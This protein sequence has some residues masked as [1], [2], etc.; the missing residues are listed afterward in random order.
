MGLTV[1]D[2]TDMLD[3][4]FTERLRAM[5]AGEPLAGADGR[6]HP[7]DS[8]TRIDPDEGAALVRLAVRVG[9]DRTLEVGLGYGFS[10]AYLLAALALRREAEAVAHVA[11]DPFQLTDWQG[12]GIA[13]ATGLIDA[14]P[15]LAKSAFECI[16][17][18]S[19]CALAGLLMQG[20]TFDLSFIDGYHRFDDVLV[21]FTLVAQMCAIGGA[22]VL[23]DMWLPGI[24][25]VA[26]FIRRNRTDFVE[27][28]TGCANLFA[29]R[30]VGEDLRSW[31]HFVPFA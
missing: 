10:T 22:I 7:I 25:S 15:W 19:D 24:A 8:T 30:R 20:R 1:G 18:P 21:D 3:P 13:T 2:G 23:H 12:I 28:D 27:V 17:A 4:P 16:H 9:A 5:H 31:D 14:S 6:L 26:D 29:V 11:I